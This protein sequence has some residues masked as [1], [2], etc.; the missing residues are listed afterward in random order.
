MRILRLPADALPVK[1]GILMVAGPWLA[2]RVVLVTLES[3]SRGLAAPARFDETKYDCFI[4]PGIVVG[5]TAARLTRLTDIGYINVNRQCGSVT[6]DCEM[7]FSTNAD[8]F[9]FV[10]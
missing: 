7:N 9:E 8:L 2:E 6:V 4:R 1:R 10:G 5:A 3:S